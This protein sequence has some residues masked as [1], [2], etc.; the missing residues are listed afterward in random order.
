[1]KLG[2]VGAGMI[3]KDVV[4]FL[5]QV[6]GIEITAI[7]SRKSSYENAKKLAEQANI[8]FVYEDLES[9]LEDDKV[10]AVYI[11]VPNDQHFAMAKLALL[12][13]KHVLVEKPFTSNHREALALAALA[14]QQDRIIYEAVSTHHLPNMLLLKKDLPKLGAIRIVALNYSQYSSRYDAFKQGLIAP[15]FDPQRSG[16]ALMDLNI[17]NLHFVLNLFG[18]PAKVKYFANVQKGIDTSGILVLEYPTFK[19][20]CM[21]AKDCKTPP[22]N[23]IQG[24]KG[25][26]IIQSS[27]STILNYQLITNDGSQTQD[28]ANTGA[29]INGSAGHHRMFDVFVEFERIVREDDRIQAEKMLALSVLSMKVQTEART[30]AGIVFQADGLDIEG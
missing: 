8:H 2:I 17:Y 15:A 30:Q 18:E 26:I 19:C 9:M 21:G 28:A 13:K 22:F 25:T 5:H 14:K 20:V 27:V 3:V 16:G 4:S 29:I 10:E 12:A 23:S 24:E 11:G 6:Q 7:C 1:M